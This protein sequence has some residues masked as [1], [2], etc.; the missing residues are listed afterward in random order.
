MSESSLAVRGLRKRYRGPGGVWVDAVAG[1]D[2]E[3]APGETLG[4]VGESGCGKTTVGRSLMMLPPPDAGSVALQGVEVTTLTSTA[5]RAMRPRM[6]MVFQ[7]PISSLNPR[8]SIA[9]AVAAPLQSGFRHDRHQRDA[10]IDVMLE[11]VGLDPSAVRDR[12]PHELS[13]GQCQRVSIARALILEPQLLICDEPVSSLDVSVQAQILNL[14][15]DCKARFALTMLFIAHDLAVVRHIS[16]RVAVMYL[17]RICEILPAAQLATQAAHP[18]TALLLASVPE[19]DVQRRRHNVVGAPATTA[20][21]L[22]P[23]SGCRFQGRCPNVS[24]RCVIEEPALR[25]IAPGHR[26]ACHHVD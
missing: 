21:P 23:P 4:L 10:R 20:T 6:Q 18:Y 3:I 22:A 17:G 25:E 19:I 1:I 12:L 15:Q 13:G 2:F 9:E 11:A 14:L 7:D 5:L 8:R 26:V 16:D 24:A